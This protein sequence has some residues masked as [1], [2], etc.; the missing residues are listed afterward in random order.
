MK[1]FLIS[2]LTTGLS[3]AALASPGDT[4]TVQ[5]HPTTSFLNYGN[6]DHPVTFPNG[7]ESYRKINMTFTLGKETC[8]PGTQYCAQWDYTVRI[9]VMTPTDTFELGRFITPYAHSSYPN[10]PL[11]W[12]HDYVFDVTDFYPI[13]QN[14]ATMRIK[15]EGYSYGFTGSLK[16]DFI[17]GTPPRDV[18]SVHKLWDGSFAYGQTTNPINDHTIAS[19]IGVPAT[20]SYGEM[21]HLISGHGGDQN[22]NCAEFCSKWY[23]WMIDGTSQ[24]QRDIWR[25]DC[26]VNWVYPQSGT[27]VYDRANW[28]P[29]DVIFPIVHKVPLSTLASS[30]FNTSLE[31]QPYTAANQSAPPSYTTAAT[32]IFYREFN[33]LID[34]GI[35][36]IVAP[37]KKDLYFRSNPICGEVKLKVKNYGKNALTSL[38]IDYGIEGQ[39]LTSYTW[40][41][42]IAAMENAII[43]LPTLPAFKTITGDHEFVAIIKAANNAIDEEPFNDT[44]RSTFSAP[45][46]WEKGNFIINMK[47]SAITQPG[48]SSKWIIRDE[49]GTIIKQRSSTTANVT[50]VDT[51]HL[52]DGCYSLEV[53]A[54]AGLG[55]RFLT[56]YTPGSFSVHRL[57]NNQS[58]SLPKYNPGNAGL[59]GDFGSG[60][61]QE[62]VVVNSE[63]LLVSIRKWN[64]DIEMTVSP[65]PAN[66]QV[67]VN[68]SG[69][70]DP[71]ATITITNVLGQVVLSREAKSNTNTID[72]SQLPAGVYQVVFESSRGSKMEKVVIS[73]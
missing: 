5:A 16:F 4:T 9:F 62:F 21:I 42:N 73:R 19:N 11:S 1:K 22:E 28:C 23:K 39:P 72:V 46:H 20:A 45:P 52:E 53:I 43:S 13:L 48:N 65:N 18:I 24:V 30:I 61:I 29:G 59:A 56:A 15:Y 51:V 70:V 47:S 14:G 7:T 27:W 54:Q 37:S 26:G 64:Q 34:A 57:D 12:K 33:H 6:F 69:L 8:P 67:N 71:T 50:N 68:I 60:F 40:T 25:N 17:E 2:L 10:M 3:I 44:A 41:G 36:D 66:Q 31:F 35:E 55:F 32:M 63:P 49:A 58:F 38:E